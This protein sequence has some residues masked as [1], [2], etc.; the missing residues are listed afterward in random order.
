MNL[1]EER[2]NR[3]PT[4]IGS[5]EQQKENI[6]SIDQTAPVVKLY[7]PFVEDLKQHGRCLL[8]AMLNE[9]PVHTLNMLDHY[10][11]EYQ[12]IMAVHFR[13]GGVTLGAEL[14]D[15]NAKSSYSLT[16]GKC[17]NAQNPPDDV[18]V[19][20]FV[21]LSPDKREALFLAMKKGYT[22]THGDTEYRRIQEIIFRPSGHG[23]LTATAV[24][25]DYYNPPTEHQVPA[26]E[27]S[28]NGQWLNRG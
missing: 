24:V 9:T 25:I 20:S 8:W 1:P 27:L 5:A 19:W 22:V 14:K 28:S 10:Y 17:I 4:A 18:D 2:K 26:E 13:A 12:K 11:I 16:D 15:K 21:E 3:T 7:R 6:E 23:T